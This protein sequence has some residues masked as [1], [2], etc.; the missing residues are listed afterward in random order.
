MS[1]DLTKV[2]S[3]ALAILALATLTS[4]SLGKELTAVILSTSAPNEDKTLVRALNR[5][6]ELA[7]YCV[8]HITITHRGD[9]QDLHRDNVDLLVLSDSSTL[10][11]MSIPAIESYLRMGGHVIALNTPMWRNILISYNNQ[12]MNKHDYERLKANELP[13]HVVFDFK[14]RD[15][16]RWVESNYPDDTAYYE[17]VDDGPAGNRAVHV[18]VGNQ[19]G[20]N[21]FLCPDLD[22]PF[23]VGNTLTVFSAR[24]SKRTHQLG[25]EWTEYDGSRW[26]AVVPLS[27]E[28][29]SYILKPEDFK[30]WPSNPN[31]GGTGDCFRPENARRFSFGVMFSHTGNVGGRHEYWVGPVGTSQ[32]N[33]EYEEY[34]QAKD[35]PVLDTLSP[36]YKV[37]RVTNAVA[38]KARSDQFLQPIKSV[39]LPKL[40]CSP[41]PRPR[42]AGFAK[43]GFWR[44]VPLMDA[45]T[46]TGDWCGSP[47]GLFLHFDGAY[48]GG[49][50]ASFGIQDPDWY[51][52]PVALRAI[53][54][55]ALRIRQGTFLVDG[56]TDHYTYFD[57]QAIQLG[58]EVVNLGSPTVQNVEGR[59]RLLNLMTKQTVVQREWHL[60]LQY[61]E[62]RVRAHAWRPE[63]WPNGGF[64]VIAEL[65]KDGKI[66]DRVS[67]EVHVW[68]P[69]KEKRFV[70]IRGGD[71]VLD[72]KRW[73]P[74]GVNY[75]P[76]SGI[77]TE[78]KEYF[79][80]WLC[81]RSYD[82]EV[83]ERDLKHIEAM[84]FNAVSIFID[85]RC[86][87]AQN[88]LDFLRRL[89]RFGLKANLS[90]RPS[91]PMDFDHQWPLIKPI[92]EHY[93]LAEN[94]TIFAYDLTW[95]P[96]WGTHND[97]KRWDAQWEK[98]IIDQYGSVE[99]AEKDWG[100]AV[101]RDTNGTV[102]NPSTEQIES[103]GEWRRMVS[104]YRRFLDILL[105][106]EYS[107]A[108]RLVRSVDPNH[109]VS[110]RM[111]NAGDPTMRW[112]GR[113]AYDWP[114][115][116]GAVDILEPEAYGRI[117]D[118]EWVRAGWFQ[119]EYARAC[120]P[121]L[122]MIWAEMGYNIWQT[123]VNE[124]TPESLDLQARFYEDFYRMMISSAADGIFF[125]WYPGGFRVY[126]NSDFGI[127]NP[128]GSDRPVTK[129]VRKYGHRFINGPDAR[130]VDYWIEIDRDKRADGIVGVYEEVQQEFWKA[131]D[132]GY[133]PGL[134]LTGTG[135]T[136]IDCPKIAV[137]NAPWTGNN[138]HKYLDGVFDSAQL[139]DTQGNRTEVRNGDIIKVSSSECPKVTV[140]VTNLGMAEWVPPS[141]YTGNGTICLSVTSDSSLRHPLISYVKHL[142]TICLERITLTLKPITQPLDIVLTLEAD[143]LGV[144][145]EKFRFKVAPLTQELK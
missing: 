141:E 82:P 8:R 20:W 115:L 91:M 107:A 144:F 47:V 128:D 22:N 65:I 40:M 134:R 108:R 39:T 103:D 24:G 10:P 125:W 112:E 50:W 13:Q 142:D 56:G 12:L 46:K 53:R 38:L 94:D 73:R 143:G 102:T 2:L 139:F 131:V 89:E 68:H 98:W 77:G 67:H 109:F 90:L 106:K 97:R 48:K 42:G 140:T 105:Y 75:M 34:I 93:R 83:I 110:F 63:Q 29:R 100:F 122:P 15:L 21:T 28:W 37:F 7:G 81:A 14:D 4:A 79:E 1:F 116:A 72:G 59:V 86:M 36:D 124:P 101:P 44:W 135:L 16:S 23:P 104:A 55:I 119:F 74:H 61:G 9:L 76:S 51:R 69:R 5:E 62:R 71:F 31:R 95:E 35:V 120:A 136:S 126:E 111:S 129:V 30:Y 32:H 145:G 70:T 43:G 118:W 25:V 18:V 64:L 85:R 123:A 11:S 57:G 58:L 99:N 84:G 19:R 113:L 130:P 133:T 138:P 6:L 45:K 54:E 137:G 27:T 96:M 114:Y 92:I 41:H 49:I 121:H 80:H 88:L 52:T 117:G 87:E 26:I 66:I 33:S 3:L 60:Q 17:I 132:S 127:I 78:D